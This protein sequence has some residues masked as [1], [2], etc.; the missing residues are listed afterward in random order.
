MDKRD[1]LKLAA[2]P[3]YIKGIYNKKKRR[4]AVPAGEGVSETWV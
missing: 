2:D 4:V 1:L 3:K